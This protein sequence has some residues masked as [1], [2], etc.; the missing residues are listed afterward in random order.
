MR[1][2]G[3]EVG[4]AAVVLV[5]QPARAVADDQRRVAARA[6]GDRRLDVDRHRQVA[7]V[8]AEAM[9]LAVGGADQ[10]VE[11]EGAQPPVELAA[12]VAG[13][14]HG[15]VA[16]DVALVGEPDLVEVIAVE[17]RDVEV[18]GGADLLE[19]LVAELV[20]AREDEPR[21]EEGGHEPRVADDRAV[22]RLDEDPGL[23]ER[24][25][26]HQRSGTR[27]QRRADDEPAALPQA[28]GGSV[29]CCPARETCSVHAAPSQ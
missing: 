18:V 9:L 24:R 29:Y 2:E 22:G 1:G 28:T 17:V 6:V 25:G 15:D 3:G 14:E 7:A 16:A 13:H 19:Q 21:P 27:Q 8:T 12:R 4:R 23:A 26:A 20:V 10:V 5:D 11:A